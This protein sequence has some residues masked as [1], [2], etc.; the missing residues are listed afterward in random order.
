MPSV[1]S[2]IESNHLTAHC[3]SS[4]DSEQHLKLKKEFINHSCA[5]VVC[6]KSLQKCPKYPRFLL[7]HRLYDLLFWKVRSV[8]RQFSQKPK[9]FC[10]HI[11]ARISFA[12]EML[13]CLSLFSRIL[14]YLQSP[15]DDLI[16][17]GNEVRLDGEHLCGDGGGE[18]IDLAG[19]LFDLTAV[20]E[21]L[22]S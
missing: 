11:N 16:V 13:L 14:R 7:C 6:L 8:K 21:G 2:C 9:S 18:G 10:P 17:A 20:D 1:T 22:E 5:C 3:D 15:T 12:E 4:K 19:V